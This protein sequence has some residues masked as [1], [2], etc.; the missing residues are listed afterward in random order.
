VLIYITVQLENKNL[1]F[2]LK[3][4][5]QKVVVN[6]Y[7]C[8]TTLTRRVTNVFEATVTV[9]SPAELLGEIGKRS[10]VY[11]KSMPLP[12]GEYRLNL[13]LRDVISGAMNNYE[14]A[15]HVRGSRPASWRRAR[16]C[17]PT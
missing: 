15:L 7:S 2:Q 6:L 17:W 11:Q 3:D 1:Q 12:P 4:G 9:D 5:M 16:L 8:I 14:L 10:S 13:V